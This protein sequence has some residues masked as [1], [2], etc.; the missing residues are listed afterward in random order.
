MVC[1]SMVEVSIEKEEIF[2][3]VNI[4]CEWKLEAIPAQN[5]KEQEA[6]NCRLNH[7]RKGYK[8]GEGLDS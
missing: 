2:P 4:T 7:M 3:K 5:L 8:V 6:N 1:R